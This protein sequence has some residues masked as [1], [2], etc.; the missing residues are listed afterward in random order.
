MLSSARGRALSCAFNR[1]VHRSRNHKSLLG[2]CSSFTFPV[3]C[4]PVRNSSCKTLE[5]FATVDPETLSGE[6]PYQV[7]N[8]VKGG[9]TL[10]KSSVTIP[11]PLNGKPFLQ[12]PD[13]QA[14]EI[15]PY[16]EA[17]KAVPKS[18]LH[19]PFKVCAREEII[20]G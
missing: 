13:T 10:P 17:L 2:S 8:L 9:W 18:G 20:L 5:S 7:Y 19:N 1:S 11:D 12:L 16:V 3:A 14:D 6:K 4:A 15:G